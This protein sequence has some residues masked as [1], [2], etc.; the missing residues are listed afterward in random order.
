M[1]EKISPIIGVSKQPMYVTILSGLCFC[2][3]LISACTIFPY[4]SQEHFYLAIP[5]GLAGFFGNIWMRWKISLYG[6]FFLNTGIGGLS[7][8]I[9]LR[10][11]EYLFPKYHQFSMI[12]IVLIV[13]SHT[14]PMWN[15]TLAKYLRTELYAP[16][17][18]A[19]KK[20]QTF[21]LYLLITVF[22][23]IFISMFWVRL[24]KGTS[25]SIV[26]FLSSII[27]ALLFPYAYRSPSSPWE[28]DLIN[29][30]E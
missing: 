30:P 4:Y 18:E 8:I 2:A 27:L 22:P 5:F 17:T 13:F 28:H 1:K 21:S 11:F 24:D 7:T 9:A 23:I 29:K 12:I 25:L 15:S 26:L 20:F 6:R 16:K 19:G 10:S 3:L 14:L